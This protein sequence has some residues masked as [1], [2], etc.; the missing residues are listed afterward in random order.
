MFKAKIANVLWNTE[1]Q[2]GF[3]IMFHYVQLFPVDWLIIF[4]FK[5][6]IHKR[7][8]QR[9][10]CPFLSK[11][12]LIEF[13][14]LKINIF[15]IALWKV[16]SSICR[17]ETRLKSQNIVKS[18]LHSKYVPGNSKVWIWISIIQSHMG[19]IWHYVN[20]SY[21]KILNNA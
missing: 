8:T 11:S 21:L 14:C 4:T 13:I 15:F 19:H 6:I 9:R 10:C 16:L 5:Q 12:Y 17:A 20:F 7:T 1:S 3:C 2:C 18:L